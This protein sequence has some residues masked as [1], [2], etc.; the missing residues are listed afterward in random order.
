MFLFQNGRFRIPGSCLL[1]FCL[2]F[3]PGFLYGQDK[4]DSLKFWSDYD[5]LQAAV[6][7]DL[8]AVQDPFMAA[9]MFL[10]VQALF[11]DPGNLARA[12]VLNPFWLSQVR[13]GMA[14]PD[15][16]RRDFL[17]DIP[18]HEWAYRTIFREALVKSFNTDQKILV[19]AGRANPRVEIADLLDDPDHF[20][21]K[22]LTLRG[23]LHVL[24]PFPAPA[25]L[26]PIENVHDALIEL[27]GKGGLATI[28]FSILPEELAPHANKVLA[29]PVPISFTGFFLLNAKDPHKGKG[30]DK[31]D[32]IRP[33]LVGQTIASHIEPT[34][35]A[36]GD[37]WTVPLRVAM[38]V[39][40]IIFVV[41]VTMILLT[42]WYRRGDQMLLDKVNQLRKARIE[43]PD[44]DNPLRDHPLDLS[45]D[46]PASPERNG[47]PGNTPQVGDKPPGL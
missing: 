43:A 19:D 36:T 45:Q 4:D 18:L 26:W 27:D 9:A 14:P 20:R 40:G 8:V 22:I 41:I 3:L 6:V 25:S 15:L 2:L 1:L 31:S 29:E 5:R 30:K 39:G 16:S 47:S 24:K 46:Q 42:R 21:G 34:P 28:V 38:I 11:D 32:I 12:P 44:A 33:L 13:D 7:A 35:A 10:E 17:T 37:G 23:K